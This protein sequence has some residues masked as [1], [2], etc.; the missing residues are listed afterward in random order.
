[1][2]AG[3]GG[4]GNGGALK[5]S[6]CTNVL[7]RDFRAVNSTASGL[8]NHVY[9]SGGANITLANVTLASSN[10]STSRGAVAV[11]SGA[12]AA[13]SDSAIIDN[14]AFDGGALYAKDS[15]L[16]LSSMTLARN[17]ALNGG[18]AISVT[19]SSLAISDSTFLDHKAGMSG[20]C[21][22]AS[23]ASNVTILGSNLTTCTSELYAGGV[24]LS[25]GSGL[26]LEGSTVQGARSSSLGGAV[27]VE[28][29][30]AVVN[31]SSISGCQVRGQVAAACSG[32]C[33]CGACAWGIVVPQH[34]RRACQPCYGMPAAAAA[35]CT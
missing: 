5:L 10:C 2:Q 35:C 15:S 3:L 19:Q 21:I 24:R 14:L 23:L 29:G 6:K 13:I 25:Q 11:V 4:S 7:I 9:I 33:T 32:L 28:N 34:V 8:G 30:Q 27:L 20:G 1:M 16:Q 22:E 26:V 31:S 17:Q 18:G 12:S